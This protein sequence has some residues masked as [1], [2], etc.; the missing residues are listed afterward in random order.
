MLHGYAGTRDH[1]GGP[2][3]VRSYGRDKS[4]TKLYRFNS[5]GFRGEEH[6][7][8]AAATI[9]VCGCS[10]SFGTGLDEEEAW[11]HRFKRVWAARRGLAAGAV[12]L[13]NFSQGAASNDYI[14]RTLLGQVARARPDLVVAQFT[15]MNRAEAFAD[16]DPFTIGPWLWPGASL[17]RR[18]LTVPWA[19]KAAVL[20]RVRSA[21]GYA[22]FY[23]PES[24]FSNAVRNIL[25]VQSACR[26][27]RVPCAI[28]WLEHERLR[29]PAF[30]G[31]A[32]LAPLA[33]LLDPACVADFGIVDPDLR[34][35]AAADGRH[36]GPRT[37]AAFADRLLGF[38]ERAATE[39]L[40]S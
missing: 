31:N 2:A 23:S 37:H 1:G 8:G 10:H 26:A 18:F 22:R 17:L 4:G 21:G 11:P 12:N 39:G 20:S 36:A 9:F 25:L 14:A 35:D 13:L 30:L 38:V 29:D 27:M 7:P 32:A 33:R 5:L 40:R 15:S 24:G 3:G 19:R 16:G 6:D 34:V 28:S